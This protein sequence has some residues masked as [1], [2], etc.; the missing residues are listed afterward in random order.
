ME[1]PEIGNAEAAP[2]VISNR[3]NS[4]VSSSSMISQGRR[5]NSVISANVR[6]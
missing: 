5:T 4:V 2:D 6:E 3:G 1:T